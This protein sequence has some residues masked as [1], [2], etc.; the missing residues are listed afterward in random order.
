MAVTV[1][2]GVIHTADGR[3]IEIP[4]QSIT[5][6]AADTSKPRTDVVYLDTNG[7][8]AKLTGELGTPAVAG[9]NTYTI[10]TTFAVGDTVTFGGVTFT[11]TASTQDA[12]NFVLGS[13]TTTSAANLVSALNANTTINAIYTASATD[14]VITITEN[15][16]GGG[17]TPGAMTVTGTGVVTAGTATTS[18]AI[19]TV[20]S[21]IAEEMI[22]VAEIFVDANE[23]FGILHTVQ[24][25]NA[26][27]K[28]LDI[29]NVKAYGAKGDGKTD[30]T[31]AL[32]K[33]I[34]SGA[35]C[36]YIPSGKYLITSTIT[37]APG[38]AI[39]GVTDAFFRETKSTDKLSIIYTNTTSSLFVL[40]GGNHIK[41]LAV[42]YYNQT[43]NGDSM[44]D[45]GITFHM[46]SKNNYAK[47]CY[48]EC[49]S[50]CGGTTIIK[51][52][53]NT[54]YT[55][56]HRVSFTPNYIAASII[57][58]NMYDTSN[59]SCV[60]TNPN[61]AWM[62]GLSISSANLRK[63]GQSGKLFELCRVDELNVS[64]VLAYGIAKAITFKNIHNIAQGG[65][66]FRD[67]VFD[68]ITTVLECDAT[69][70]NFGIIFVGLKATFIRDE[71]SCLFR[72][73][74]N[75]KGTR[76]QASNVYITASKTWYPIIADEGCHD[77]RAIINVFNMHNP[78]DMLDN[79][80]DNVFIFGSGFGGSEGLT[81]VNS[82]EFKTSNYGY[83]LTSGL[84][85]N[86]IQ[87]KQVAIICT[88]GE[89]I[90]TQTFYF[91]KEFNNTP[92]VIACI[93]MASN[94]GAFST[95]VQIKTGNVSTK[96]YDLVLGSETAFS[97]SGVWMVSVLAIGS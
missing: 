64:N 18:T 27:Y 21:T 55:D 70:T 41:N 30:D 23:S 72:F 90:A 39:V 58:D 74:K 45:T 20:A 67:C 60:H 28:M 76:L 35:T 83:G 87:A 49:C 22:S 71:N 32:Q 44:I 93:N 57:M 97:S 88:K 66:T 89:K 9:S 61:V 47:G 17:N 77:N 92:I 51:S 6:D 14:S 12:T 53:D 78:S 37:V 46:V 16:A 33:A 95:G 36:V 50:V 96:K 3:R 7:T 94:V 75:S 54:D 73:T 91:D 85:L 84:G 38:V 25:I 63:I 86:K 69:I 31:T 80:K 2:A 13:D 59:I 82:T 15:T 43:L 42:L 8:I 79:G 48:I 10:S 62:F 19:S 68:N 52:I 65:A 56:I 40:T 26:P 29:V 4:E 34:D 11:C 5:L 81:A 24:R 1:S